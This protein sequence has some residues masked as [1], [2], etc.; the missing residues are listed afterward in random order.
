MSYIATYFDSVDAAS[1][2]PDLVECSTADEF[3]DYLRSIHA[4][5]KA[6][7]PL[8]KMASFNGHRCD[9][10]VVEFYGAQP[11]AD[12]QKIS[13]EV[14][15]EFFQT[16]GIE[17]VFH[18]T[19]GEGIKP[20]HCWRVFARFSKPLDA[21][22]FHEQMS[23]LNGV[24]KLLDPDATFAAESW[25]PPSQAFYIGSGH[26]VLVSHGKPIDLVE[27]IGLA[28]NSGGRKAK[29][30]D[31]PPV[32][33]VKFAG[34]VSPA[35]AAKREQLLGALRNATEGGRHAKLFGVTAQLYRLV[36][37]GRLDPEGLEDAIIAAATECGI[38]D[39]INNQISRGWAN[40][41]ANPLT[42]E[43]E[44]EERKA[45]WDARTE[46]RWDEIPAP[47]L[48][49]SPE[50]HEANEE[51][52]RL[53]REEQRK[54]NALIGEGEGD[55]RALPAIMTLEQMARRLVLVGGTHVADMQTGRNRGAEAA[56]REYAASL[57]NWEA[58][59]K[60]K[61]APAIK[62]WM[63]SPARIS[64]D[65]LTWQPGQ[66]ALCPLPEVV[67]A[68]DRGL[69]TWRGLP[70]L[71]F[72]DD[73]EALV[74]PFLEHVAYL[75]PVE[76]ERRRFLQWLAHIVQHPEIL[77]HTSY[78][79]VTPSFGIGRN[80]LAGVIVRVLSG[81]AAAGLDLA[82]TLLGSYNGRLSRKLIAIVDE[83]REGIGSNRYT[84]G[85]KLKQEITAEVRHINPKFGLQSVEKNCCRWLMFS[86]HYDAVP[87]PEGDRRVIVIENPT[88][89]RDREYYIR[90]Y[91]LLENRSFIGAVRKYLDT[92]DL[93]GFNP[94][95]HA[96]MNAAKQEAIESMLSPVDV[97]IREY[98]DEC[99]KPLVVL[100]AIRAHITFSD[101]GAKV[102]GTHLRHAL[103]R[104]GVGK[105]TRVRLDP[106]RMDT[107]APV[108]GRG[109]TTEMVKSAPADALKAAL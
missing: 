19:H 76:A 52:A 61:S 15:H 69:N 88:V 71:P 18:A 4:P 81:H 60:P 64:V 10:N 47:D 66:P 9:A 34:V 33:A 37:G 22:G 103:Q 92:L 54:L 42:P 68:G 26:E 67:D 100:S 70:L 57:H 23:K 16:L 104:A 108:M 96:P 46:A 106:L 79:F 94:G 7:A 72:P 63:Q 55:E 11:D 25:T 101:P 43:R 102:S 12:S 87:L 93:T 24:L 2:R 91:A 32:A 8:L 27:G 84:L 75:V 97:A 13:V 38:G 45:Y 82:Q 31:A 5:V 74:Q 99:D 109:W 98:L 58:D 95:E 3:A 65:G 6:S 56:A 85:E 59:G 90:I 51:A 49:L 73:W 21:E 14:A 48:P 17:A 89:C 105:G 86:Q 41:M 78:L 53:R 28:D 83:V 50:E 36:S 40:G 29:R 77:P 44:A 1:A 35:D 107:V 30:Y 80:W 62:L 20:H 39:S